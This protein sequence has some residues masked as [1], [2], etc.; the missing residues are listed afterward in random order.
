M[1]LARPALR[2]GGETRQ[3]APNKKEKKKKNNQMTERGVEEHDILFP[4]VRWNGTERSMEA[5]GSVVV[6]CRPGI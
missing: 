3:D 4:G 2:P 6:G 5:L 1:Y